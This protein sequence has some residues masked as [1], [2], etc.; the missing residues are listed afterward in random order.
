MWQPGL[1]V[2]GH[3]SRGGDDGVI[4]GPRPKSTGRNES[5]P[6][7]TNAAPAMNEEQM[8]LRNAPCPAR[9][10]TCDVCTGPFWPAH[11]YVHWRKKFP[12]LARKMHRK[13]STECLYIFSVVCKGGITSPKFVHTLHH[14]T[15]LHYIT[16]PKL[17]ISL[18]FIAV[19]QLL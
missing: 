5:A 2:I 17:T 9:P 18:S 11:A 7:A 15:T 19:L 1:A 10:E 14:Y 8:N 6:C 13:W 16:F 3:C 4:R 12:A